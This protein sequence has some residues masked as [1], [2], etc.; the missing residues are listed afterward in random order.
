MKM[1]RRKRRKVIEI[2]HGKGGE[3]KNSTWRKERY[4]DTAT[5]E[6]KENQQIIILKEQGTFNQWEVAVAGPQGV[7]SRNNFGDPLGN[8]LNVLLWHLTDFNM[9]LLGLPKSSKP[10]LRAQY[11]I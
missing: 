3:G 6:R 2:W 7:Q 10:F 9:V 4:G 1:R 8:I 5:C 11:T